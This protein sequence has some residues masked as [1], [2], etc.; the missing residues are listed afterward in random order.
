MI[1]V[2]YGVNIPVQVNTQ[3]LLK[4]Y[5]STHIV[6]VYICELLV[7]LRPGIMHR[8]NEHESVFQEC[9]LIL[10]HPVPLIQH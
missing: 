5:L 10:T 2:N 3:Q 9:L 6:T 7:N 4:P 1:N 8:R